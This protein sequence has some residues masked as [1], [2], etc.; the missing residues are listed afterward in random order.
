MSLERTLN[1][2]SGF[3]LG[4]AVVSVVTYFFLRVIEATKVTARA[5]ILQH[6]GNGTMYT[7]GTEQK[8][9]SYHRLEPFKLEGYI[10]LQKFTEEDEVAIRQYIR[11]TRDG[12]LIKHAEKFYQ[13]RQD[14]P[15]VYITPKPSIY[16]IEI[17]IQQTRGA[18]KPFDWEFYMSG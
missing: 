7:D 8:V 6:L 13:G 17:T 10:N 15:M 14:L 4:V 16:G 1:L 11:I 3:I 9:L 5:A 2:I 18:F 12:D